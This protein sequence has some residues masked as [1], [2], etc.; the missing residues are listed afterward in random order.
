MSRPASQWPE[1]SE[2]RKANRQAHIDGLAQRPV[3]TSITLPDPP[4]GPLA[5]LIDAAEKR[6]HVRISVSLES[7]FMDGRGIVRLTRTA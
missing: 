2:Y 6:R 5:D 7:S 1:W 3:G 4:L